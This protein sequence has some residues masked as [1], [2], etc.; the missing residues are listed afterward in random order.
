MPSEEEWSVYAAENQVGAEFRPSWAAWR[1]LSFLAAWRHL[2]RHLTDRDA[3]GYVSYVMRQPWFTAAFPGVGPVT[4][5]LVPGPSW[6]DPRQDRVI[7]LGSGSR[8]TLQAAEWDLL[9]ELAHIVTSTL[10]GIP[11][12]TPL[13]D[14]VAPQR[15]G[16]AWKTNYIFLIQNMLGH[17]AA[18]HLTAAIKPDPAP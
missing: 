3:I 8:R 11:Q 6:C 7:R 17:R 2:R 12:A 9:H 16:D 14:G 15:H 13:K 1:Y 10:P 18:R 4:V 5:Q